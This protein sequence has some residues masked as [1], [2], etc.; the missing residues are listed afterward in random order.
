MQPEAAKF[1]GNDIGSRL[2]DFWGIDD[3]GEL[4]GAFKRMKRKLT[5]S[6]VFN[7]EKNV[8]DR[9]LEPG[10]WYTGGGAPWARFGSRF[11][12]LQIKADLEGCPLPL[13]K[14]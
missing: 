3:E 5:P 1:V 13:Y 7:V 8:T 12:A 2:D 6:Y 9:Y 14:A 4:R 10:I 11:L